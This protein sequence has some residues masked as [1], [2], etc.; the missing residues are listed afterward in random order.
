MHGLM[1]SV[2]ELRRRI[3]EASRSV[4]L[5]QLALRPQCGFASGIGGNL[6]DKDAQWRELEIMLETARRVWG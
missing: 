5:A 2:E 1:E 6:L 3:E 4:P